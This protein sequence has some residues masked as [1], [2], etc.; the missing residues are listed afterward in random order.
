MMKK[1]DSSRFVPNSITVARTYR[2]LTVSDLAKQ[3]NLSR[4]LVSSIENGSVA[5]F[6]GALAAL[7]ATLRFPTG[8]FYEET[9]TPEPDVLH[10]RKGARVRERSIQRARSHAGL[11][12]RIVHAST[13]FVKLPPVCIPAVAPLA[14]ESVE[15]AAEM[16]RGA[17]NMRLDTPI[18]NVIQ[19]IE[20]SGAFVATCDVGDVP[21]DGFCWVAS[22]PLVLLN[23]ESPWSRRRHSALHEIGHV[24]LHGRE[25]PDDA[26]GQ[27]HRFAGAVLAPRGAFARE[28][29]KPRLRFDW[30]ALMS[31]KQR[32]GMSLQALIHRAFDLE[33]IDAAEYRTANIHI[34]QCGWRVDE[35]GELEPE[36]P[37]RYAQL[38]SGLSERD[39]IDDLAITARLSRTN[40]EEIL[41]ITLEEHVTRI[42]PIDEGRRRR[43]S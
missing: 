6:P 5:P 36:Q 39:K 16:F 4:Q 24:S 11:V 22:V 25:R 42:V 19:T 1:S 20:A 35:P 28:F 32:W 43:E 18:G 3:A 21:V 40:I 9:P 29:P 34:R 41:D 12:A 33:L 27:A 13:R 37:M 38:M 15:R 14:A 23:K 17:L 8:F 30:A 10:F 2:S 31:M 7:V 26:E